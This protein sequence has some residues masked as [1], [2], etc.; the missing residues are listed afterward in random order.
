MINFTEHEL[1]GYQC[2]LDLY[3]GQPL[4]ERSDE[5]FYRDIVA[6]TTQ[7]DSESFH[8]TKADPK[9]FK[10]SSLSPL[11][12][13]DTVQLSMAEKF[14]LTTSGGTSIDVVPSDSHIVEAVG[15][16]EMPKHFAA[17]A[18]RSVRKMLWEKKVA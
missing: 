16:G 6:A 11:V 18:L 8:L 13:N 4:N 5:Y 2:A 12:K 15:G 10:N 7:T 9:Q 17:K 14:L 3:T 1:V